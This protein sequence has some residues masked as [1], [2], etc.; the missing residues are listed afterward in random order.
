VPRPPGRHRIRKAGHPVVL[1]Q[2][3]AL[4]LKVEGASLQVR[5][6]E[7]EPRPAHRHPPANQLTLRH[8]RLQCLVDDLYQAWKPQLEELSARIKAKGVELVVNS[9]L[10]L[11]TST[12]GPFT[13]N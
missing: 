5:E 7:V 9:L 2:R 10:S 6:E 12:S 1:H 11:G 8:Q 3:D 13:H 4:H